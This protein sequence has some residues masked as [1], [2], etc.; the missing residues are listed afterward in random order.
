MTGPRD[1]QRERPTEATSPG[2]RPEV[3]KDLDVPGDDDR[4]SVPAS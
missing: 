2:V 1:M 3:I 4:Q